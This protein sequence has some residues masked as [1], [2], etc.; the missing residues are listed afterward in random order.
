M[1]DDSGSTA[2]RRPPDGSGS[3]HRSRQHSPRSNAGY[4]GAEMAKDDRVEQERAREEAEFEEPGHALTKD[5]PG[6]DAKTAREVAGPD[7]PGEGDVDFDEGLGS[8][9]VDRG[10]DVINKGESHGLAAD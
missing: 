1:R 2:K 10:E 7:A 9:A 4:K 5:T 6:L 3:R 8:G